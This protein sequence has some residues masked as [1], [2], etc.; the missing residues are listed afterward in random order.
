M[1]GNCLALLLGWFV[2]GWL[3]RS[4][5]RRRR[6]VGAVVLL[7]AAVPTVYSLNRG[8]WAG[9]GVAAAFVLLRLAAR[10]HLAPAAAMVAVLAVGGAVLVAS[11]LGAIISER[12]AHPHSNS[13]RAFT[14]V[15]TL[16]VLAYS[17][18][19]GFGATRQPLGSSN[20]IAA[21]PSPDCPRCGSPPLGSN[22]QLWA[23]LIAQGV[24]GV[25]LFVGFFLKN[26]WV[27]RHDRTPI[28]DAGLLAIVLSLFFMFV[29]NAVLMPLLISFLSI[30]V[31]WRNHQALQAERAK[32]DLTP[33]VG[34]AAVPR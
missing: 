30:A 18:V 6:I 22:G 4:E 28:G 27:F 26:L 32:E 2:I 34:A 33:G 13:A 24:V 9:L 31:L 25:V 20:S 8:M 10:G 14:T 15:N 1:W 21:G 3:L 12:L 17:P 29:Y 5:S 23:N 16:D 19:M 7:L 11:P